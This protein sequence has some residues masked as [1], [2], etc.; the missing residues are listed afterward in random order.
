MGQL[1]STR[2]ATKVVEPI[3]KGCRTVVYRD[4]SMHHPGIGRG[5]LPRTGLQTAGGTVGVALGRRHSA[6]E[7]NMVRWGVGAGVDAGNGSEG[8]EREGEG[9][10]EVFHFVVSLRNP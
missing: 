2:N 3:L 7:G 1:F 5:I 9:A 8:D 4:G 10:N 6:R